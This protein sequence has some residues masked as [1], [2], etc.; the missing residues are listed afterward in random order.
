VRA[1]RSAGARHALDGIAAVVDAAVAGRVTAQDLLRARQLVERLERE[2]GPMD[3]KRR[4]RMNGVMIQ[5]LL[6]HSQADCR[7]LRSTENV[8]RRSP[9]QLARLRSA[10]A[11]ACGT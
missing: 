6:T 2:P 5:A 1:R 3:E 11:A 8:A 7:T 4:A 9:A 10:V